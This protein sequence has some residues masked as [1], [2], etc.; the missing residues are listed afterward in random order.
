MTT[1]LMRARR[2]AFMGRAISTTASSWAWARG[3]VGVI[4]T[5]GAT[6]ASTAAAADGTTAAVVLR[7]IVLMRPIA[8]AKAAG[9][10]PG[11]RRADPA[12]TYRIVPHRQAC[13]ART[14][15][16]VAHLAERPMPQHHVVHRVADLAADRAAEVAADRAVVAGTAGSR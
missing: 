10:T 5:A 9:L 2:S 1:H 16:V 6:I 8:D 7:L 15:R 4:A 12:Q 13:P 11:A 14:Y 3:P